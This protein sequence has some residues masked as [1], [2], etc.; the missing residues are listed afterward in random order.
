L[1]VVSNPYHGLLQ[2]IGEI[3]GP[4]HGQAGLRPWF[5]RGAAAALAH[6]WNLDRLADCLEVCGQSVSQR[7]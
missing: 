4:R 7:L 3:A 5:A 1:L 6:E 2:S